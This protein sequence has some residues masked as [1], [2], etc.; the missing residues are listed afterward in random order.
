MNRQQ[1]THIAGAFFRRLKKYSNRAAENFNP[2]SV[3]RFRVEYKKLRAFLRMLSQENNRKIKISKTLKHAYSVAGTIRDL[4]LQ[5][6]RLAETIKQKFKKLQPASV[7]LQDKINML[8]TELLKTFSE[9]PIGGCKKKIIPLLP[10]KY[11]LSHFKLFIQNKLASINALLSNDPVSDASIHVIRKSL[12]DLFYN[13]QL[14]KGTEQKKLSRL[15]YKT[16]NENTFKQLLTELGSF[17]DECVAID[18]LKK[19]A[20]IHTNK[21]GEIKTLWTKEKNDMKQ[22]LI[23][24]IKETIILQQPTA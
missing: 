13:L 3:H 15:I 21:D 18:L 6:Q 8:E 1:I 9:N 11:S 10:D 20:H 14:Y 23:K 7:P 5:Q 2:E 12:K 22:L 19:H 24:K 17:Q 16:R 4:Q